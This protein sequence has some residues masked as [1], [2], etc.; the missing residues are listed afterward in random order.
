MNATLGALERLLPKTKTADPSALLEA[1]LDYAT[2]LGLTLYEAQEAA[3]LEI[4][5]GNHVILNTPTGSGKSLVALGACFKALSEGQFAYYTAPIKAL[6]TEKFFELCE[7][8]GANNVGMMTGDA[9]VNRD[10]PILCCTAEI[11]ANVALRNP[12]HAQADWVI[13]DEFHY[14]ADR[15]RGTAWQIPLLTLPRTRF[16]LMSATLGNPEFFRADIERRTGIPATLVQSTERPVPLD[17]KYQETPLQQTLL[18][19]LESE[20]VPVYIVHFSQRSASEQAQNLMS[21]N[22]LTRDE[23]LELRAELA[24]FRFDSPFGK[25]LARFVNHGIGVHHAGMLPKYRRLVERLAQT[26]LLRIICGTDTLGV[27]VNIPIRTVLFTQLYKF[28]GTAARILSARDFHQI[29]GR[30]GRRGFD[31]QGSVIVQAPEH[32]IENKIQRDKAAGDP[33]KLRKLHPKKPPER[34]YKPYT[35]ETLNQLIVASPEPLRSSIQLSHGLLLNAL[36]S[37]GGCSRAK[38]ILRDCH[39]PPAQRRRLMKEAFQL[40]RG[41][42]EAGVLELHARGVRVHAAL[43]DDFSLNQALSL[44]ALAAFDALDME[45]E[46][47][48]LTLLS[49]VESILENPTQ[50]LMR[51][52]DAL[53]T[54]KMAELRAAGVEY[55][56]RIAELEKIEHKKPEAEFI[57]STFNMFAAV[58]PWA[59]PYNVSPKS[60][61]RDM[62]EQAASF[63]QYIKDYGLARS[64]GVL[65]RY[66]TDVYRTLQQTVPDKF[67]T[68]EFRDLEDWLGAE[69]RAV[70]ASLLDEWERLLH[71]KEKSAETAATPAPG[72]Y[73]VT[74]NARAFAKSVRNAAWRF[75]VALGRRDFAAASEALDDAGPSGAPSSPWSALR[76]GQALEAYFAE[77]AVVLIDAD[78]RSAA[79]AALAPLDGDR[80]ELRQVLSDPEEHLDWCA[81]FEIDLAASREA[82]RP[83]LRL[84]AL[85]SELSA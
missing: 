52:V 69:L 64:E 59:K 58:N 56:E 68:D 51:Q 27:G 35:V 21:L 30:A 24:G 4:F 53:K 54:Q 37:E 82:A 7:K 22:Y 60:V 31:A 79:R 36:V 25:E 61:A 13:M 9:T 85:S 57:Y 5:S 44:Y 78:A 65:L 38:R 77:H 19:L 15:E 84:V 16:L 46:H 76:L 29:A 20:K 40:F 2:G 74:A 42:V 18:S 66:L 70:D 67:R 71:P 45:S 23:K 34:G 32:E 81:R 39:E 43:Q 17:W 11:L 41:L 75:V 48:A 50:V 3:L 10:A 80:L 33:K 63:N 47:Y 8:L 73:D 55:E 26:G 72:P 28:D 83:V 49:V 12:E 6:V 14:Y 1:F 62:Y